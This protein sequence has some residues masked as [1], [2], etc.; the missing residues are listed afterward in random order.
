LGE[1]LQQGE[2][3]DLASQLPEEVAH[4]LAE[5]DGEVKYDLNDFYQKVSEREGSELQDAI[6]H[7]KAVMSVLRDAVSI[8][9]LKDMDTQLPPEFADLFE[10]QWQES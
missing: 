3:D 9:E 5:G 6:H 2:R 7:S 4:Y 8:G 1:R 10:R